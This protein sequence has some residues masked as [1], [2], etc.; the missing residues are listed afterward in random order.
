MKDRV[1][2]MNKNNLKTGDVIWVKLHGDNHVQRGIRPAVI[3]QNNTGNFHSPTIEVVPMTSRQTKSKL[4]THVTVPAG[5]AGLTKPSI[6]QCEGV[7]PVS[8]NDIV[9]YI[10]N[11][12]DEYM[13]QISIATI[14][15]MPIISYLTIDQITEIY[16]HV[17]SVYH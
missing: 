10:G 5:I 13:A 1:R 3:V 12:P 17:S 2:D 16:D 9:G 8:K 14:I 6:V 7:R 15:S 4:P 11:M